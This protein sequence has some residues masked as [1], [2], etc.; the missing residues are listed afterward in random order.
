MHFL[1]ELSSLL[2][3]GPFIGPRQSIARYLYS[4]SDKILLQEILAA[5]LGINPSR[6]LSVSTSVRFFLSFFL[7][8]SF[9]FLFY[10]YLLLLQYI[11][12][13]VLS[14]LLKKTFSP[15]FHDKMSLSLFFD[16]SSVTSL[17][18]DQPRSRNHNKMAFWTF[19]ML[20]S[21]NYTL[22]LKSMLEPMS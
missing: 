9:L 18:R 8:L 16:L 1:C 11:S 22:Q 3:L 6:Y 10:L 21:Q 17:F 5:A 2:L 4:G 12:P 14:F 19:R 15:S 7:S 13:T 20:Q